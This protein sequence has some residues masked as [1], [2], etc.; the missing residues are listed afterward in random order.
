MEIA[1]LS[2]SMESTSGLVYL[3]E[4]LPSIGTEG[5]DVAALA[6]GKNRIKGQ[7]GFTRTRYPSKHNH[8]VA[9]QVQINIFKVVLPSTPNADQ[10]IR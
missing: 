1:G 3:A 8:P 10:V 9:G 2:P 5:F 7:G 6:L 4:K